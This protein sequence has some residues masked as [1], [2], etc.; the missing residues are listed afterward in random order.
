MREVAAMRRLA[1]VAGVSKNLREGNET[2]SPLTPTPVLAHPSPPSFARSLARSI[3]RSLDRSPPGK[4]KETAA[5]QA[6]R[7]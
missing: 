4:G 6:M 3:F 7:R 5:T 2:V 1:C